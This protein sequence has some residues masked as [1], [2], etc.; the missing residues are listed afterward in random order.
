MVARKFL[1]SY[2]DDTFDVDY[3]TDD[4]FEV[5]KFQLF[6]LTSIPP[7]N[8][9]ILGGDDDHFV[10]DDS[11]LI[12]ISD[13]LRLVSLDEE[14]EVEVELEIEEEGE[15]SNQHAGLGNADQNLGSVNKEIEVK[16]DGE[17]KSLNQ[18]SELLK[19]DE[20]LARMLQA[21]EEALLLQKYVAGEDR[22][23]MEQ[24]IRPYIRQV[25]MYEDLNNQ[26]VARKTVPVDELEEK[27]LVSLA[28]EG[29]FKPSKSEQ[30]HA[31]LLQLL[32]WFKQS[33]RWVNAPPCDGCGSQTISQGMGVA[34]PS[35]LDFGGSRVELYRCN[36]CSRITRFPRYNDPLKLVETR[37][38]RCGEW[39][40]CFTLY[41]RAFGYD[42]RL[43][44]DFT[45]HV[46]TECFSH[47]LG[48]WMHL[49][50]CEGIYDRPLLY[51]KGWNKKLNY[52]IAI[53]K[54]GVYDVTKR[55]TRKWHE[56]LTR[57]NITRESVLSD[58][59]SNITRECRKSIT[60]Q[61]LSIL[62]ERDRNE[63]KELDRQSLSKEDIAISLPGRQ[64]GDK[65]WR[66]LRQEFGSDD[67][68]S[69]SCSSCPVRMCIDE[70]VTRIYK[71]FSPLLSLFVEHS[72]S[73]SS[74][75]D[76][77]ET[78]KGILVNLRR[79]P[80]RIRRISVDSVS[81]N[82]QIFVH[83]M[84]PSLDEFLDVLSLKNE[85]DANGK[86]NFSLVGDP[87]RTSL[88]LPVA[89]DAL[90]STIHNLKVC[91]NFGKDSLC[92]PLLK[93]NRIHSGS[94]LASGEELPFGIATSVFDGIQGSK[95]EE[96][97]GARGCWITYK[98]FNDQMH[99][100]VAYEFMSANDAPERDPM[101]WILEGS[102][103]AGSSWHI[104]DKQ[105]SQ[106]FENRFERRI[107]TIRSGLQLNVF[108]F[109]FLAVRDVQA[110]SRLQLGSIDLYARS[111]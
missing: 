107:F 58:V 23:Q 110:T 109:R 103:D 57:R 45:D 100:L 1:V 81:S 92:L 70:H 34:L 72:L 12:A 62:E 63:T 28:K 4:G 13:K 10:S 39:A 18:D 14:V 76:A 51:E 37:R 29:N 27:A 5:F 102:D 56:V 3:D 94:V 104:L 75:V 36:S 105:A 38:G 67:N 9:K 78:L 16:G 30:D 53:A 33:F 90:D 97:N 111:I 60:P 79:T 44:L 83:E 26:E 95:W 11:D 68:C 52:V 86:G 93:L 55:Y 47:L 77:L 108:R 59:L 65:T 99:E 48:R 35:E 87:V 106:M 7:D 19:A 32:S 69:L 64:S 43:I 42:S 22:Q 101:D 17:G 25:L 20:E 31:F 24:R 98:V 40:N 2:N 89:I 54:D 49:D 46:W 80:F 8:Q 21:E 41:C 71:A 73:R 82:A 84:L 74:V 15:S 85:L 91:E 61:M 50:P 96:P 6:S 88:A 66:I